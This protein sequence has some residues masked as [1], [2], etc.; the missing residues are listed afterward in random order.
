MVSIPN[1]DE[2]IAVQAFRRCLLPGSQLYKELTMHQVKTWVEVQAYAWAQIRWEKD[3]AKFRLEL[4]ERPKNTQQGGYVDRRSQQSRGKNWRSEPY[5]TGNRGGPR[6][7]DSKKPPVPK[8]SEHNFSVSPAELVNTLQK[9]GDSVRWPNKLK[10]E[11]EKRNPDKWCHFHDDHGHRTEDYI[12]LRKEVV[13][14]MKKGMLKDIIKNN[15]NTSR[16]GDAQQKPVHSSTTPQNARTIHMII[17]GSEVSGSTY[18][19]AK[20]H[21]RSLF[22]YDSSTRYLG[23]VMSTSNI[24]EQITFKSSEIQMFSYHDD[25]L[26]ITL[27]IAN[28]NVKRVLID[29][30]SSVN[31]IYLQTVKELNLES[32]IIQA[33]TILVFGNGAPDRTVGEISLVTQAVGVNQLI[34]FQVMDCPSAYNVLLGRPWIHQMRSVPSTLHQSIKFHTPWG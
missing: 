5:S 12:Q 17:G 22:N 30:G 23:D 10:R 2:F 16:A 24:N 31:I 1:C 13:E 26:V 3:D 14:L 33:P 29:A 25:A 27:M 21:A 15:K 11:P 34:K 9:L 28:C 19:A 7:D 4:A 8:L 6:G 32:Q 18:S 20:R